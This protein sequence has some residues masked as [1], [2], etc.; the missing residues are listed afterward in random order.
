MVA[1]LRF[2]VGREETEVLEDHGS[3]LGSQEIHV[4]ECKPVTGWVF[5]FGRQNRTGEQ[6][7][8][9]HIPQNASKVEKFATRLI[10]RKAQG[11]TD[12]LHLGP[13]DFRWAPT[14]FLRYQ[15][16]DLF[17]E[18]QPLFGGIDYHTHL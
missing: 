4:G 7:I 2:P 8:A 12:D 13:K 5:A 1:L 10:F 14:S 17:P 16:P 6:V 15:L 3:F 18:T 9:A 11:S